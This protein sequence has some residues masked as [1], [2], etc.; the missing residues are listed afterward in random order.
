MRAVHV[1]GCMLMLASS[2]V[3]SVAAAGGKARECKPGAAPNPFGEIG[4]IAV[5]QPVDYWGESWLLVT[6]KPQKPDKVRLLSASGQLLE[7]GKPPATVEPM[8][9]LARGRALYALG[10]GRSQTA[11]KTDVVLMRWGSDPRPRLTVLRTVDGIEGQVS[12]AFSNEFLMAS[13]AERAA[14]GKLHRMASFLDSEELHVGEAHDLGPDNGAAARTLA[15]AKGFMQ[16]WTSERG[17]MRASFD[18]R[19]KSLQPTAAVAW[20][21]ATPVRG[22]LQCGERVWLT[23][24]AGKELAVSSGPANGPI[25][26]LARL[27][28]PP[29]AELLPMQCVDD[30]VV[31]GHRT[32]AAKEDN[33]VFWVSTVDTTGKVR[34][35][36]VKDMRGNADDIRLPQFSMAGSKLTGWWVEG[37]AEA[38]KVWSRAISCD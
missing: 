22:L 38:T 15:Q 26:E 17:V 14:D 32:L 8:T 35:R 19:G 37:Q 5:A 10:K 30:A 4:A 3:V 33:I 21:G 6:D 25:A 13:W 7:F 31:I 29:S 20:A 2:L 11:G 24:D 16:L 1:A 28:L 27:P 23:H 9:W 36:R 12:G 34:D 18:L